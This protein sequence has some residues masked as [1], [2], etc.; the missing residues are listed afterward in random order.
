MNYSASAN[1]IAAASALKSLRKVRTKRKLRV[2]LSFFV[3]WWTREDFSRRKEWAQFACAVTARHKFQF[4]GRIEIRDK[5][6]PTPDVDT[7]NVDL[8]L[9]HPD[10]S[11]I[12][13]IAETADLLQMQADL[14]LGREAL[15]HLDS[16]NIK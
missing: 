1:L 10:L 2:F 14:R 15:V 3:K 5:E 13:D 12:E 7:G 4:S 11:V 16:D 8:A 6:Y 9:G